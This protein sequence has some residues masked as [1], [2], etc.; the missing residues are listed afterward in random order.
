MVSLR[1][2]SE[3]EIHAFLKALTE[4]NPGW[5]LWIPGR[6]K[7][8]WPLRARWLEEITRVWSSMRWEY[9]ISIERV[10]SVALRSANPVMSS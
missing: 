7:F 6:A 10:I 3:N 8:T 1:L 2:P 5:E 9:W 4:R